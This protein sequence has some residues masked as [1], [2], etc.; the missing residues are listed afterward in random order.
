[1]PISYKIDLERKI[2][3]TT[4]A[5]VCTAAEAEAYMR[6]LKED[7]QFQPTFRQLIDCRG[8][9]QAVFSADDVRHIAETSLF[10]PNSRRAFL[11][12]SDLQFGLA[13]MFETYRNLR[14]EKGIRVFRKEEEAMDWLENGAVD[15]T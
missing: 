15:E 2:V 13:R 7:P 1:M 6:Q 4:S 9:E 11:V 5:G 10:S 8:S 14:G 12:R 3:F